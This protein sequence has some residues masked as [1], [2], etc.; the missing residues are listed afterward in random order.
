[1]KQ[2]VGIITMHRVKNYGSVL[3][4]F[5]L[6]K[7]IDSLGYKSEVIDYIY[8]NSWQYDRG[9]TPVVYNWKNKIAKFLWLK[10]MWRKYN[11]MDRFISNNIVLSPKYFNPT[12]FNN[13]PPIYDIYL[14][15]SDQVWNPKYTKGD[16]VFF[17]GSINSSNKISYS[18]S[19][20]LDKLPVEYLEEYK[21][22]LSKYKYIS[23][24]E[25]NG[26]ILVKEMIGKDVPVVLDPTLLLN[27]EQWFSFIKKRKPIIKGHYILLYI[28]D[29]AVNPYEILNSFFGNK[30]EK[31]K[32]IV[33]IGMLKDMNCHIDRTMKD[34][35]IEDFLNLFYYSDLVI[36]SSFHGTA[37]AV[38][39][40]K[41]LLSIVPNACDDRQLTLLNLLGLDNCILNDNCKDFSNI[42]MKQNSIEIQNKLEEYR[43][44]SI[45]YLEKALSSCR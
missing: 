35:S 1:M 21:K 26:K 28:L 24:R 36:T 3:Q 38:N 13:N 23:V 20:A 39:F 33:S 6:Q 9:V 37:F 15:G 19:F 16:P 22:H 34:A 18:S 42:K 27:K 5:A 30:T 10:P 45:N 40:G 43:I 11:K 25:D 8:P 4:T 2:T 29:Y 32:K 12:D 17:L 41:P 31:S 14:T 7:V 44:M